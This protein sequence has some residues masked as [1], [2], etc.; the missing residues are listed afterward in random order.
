MRPMPLHQRFTLAPLALAAAMAIALAAG[1]APLA[2]AQ[3]GA[4]TAEATPIAINI[5]AQPLGQALNELARQANLQMTFP[6]EMVAGIQAPAVVGQLTARQALD[7]MLAGS[8]LVASVEGSSVVVRQAAPQQSSE[9]ALPEVTVTAGAEAEPEV[10]KEVIRFKRST[11]ATKFDADILETPASISSVSRKLIDE[12]AIRQADQALV[13]VPGLSYSGG[14]TGGTTEEFLIRGFSTNRRSFMDGYRN[15]FRFVPTDLLD[16]ERIDV[17][18]GAAGT[19]YGTAFPGGIVNYGLKKPQAESAHSLSASVGRYDYQRYEADSTGPITDDRT[20]QYRLLAAWQE[21]NLPASGQNNDALFDDRYRVKTQLRWL[22]PTG[23]TLDYS[24]DYYYVDKPIAGGIVFLRDG[25]FTFDSPPLI[26]EGSV[27]E[28]WNRRHVLEYVQPFG[29]GWQVLFGALYHDSSWNQNMDVTFG[30]ATVL[31]G[32]NLTRFVNINRDKSLIEQY[33]VEVSG[34]WQA[35]DWLEMRTI[36]GIEWVDDQAVVGT[37]QTV[38]VPNAIDP[39]N[40]V[41]GPRPA[42][43]EALGIEVSTRENGVFVQNLATI[44][45]KLNLLTGLRYLDYK[46]RDYLRPASIQPED[47]ALDY[48]VSASYR[49]RP[50]LAPFA[51]Y[52]TS[53]ELQFGTLNT[54]DVPPARRSAQIEAGVKSELFDDDLLLTATVYRIDQRDRVETIPGTN[55]PVGELVGEV[56]SQGFEFEFSGKVSER[57]SLYGGYAYTDA[58]VS[59][60]VLVT[61]GIAHQ[62]K[63]LVAV[64]TH[65]ASLYADY[66]FGGELAGLSL[67]A[68]VIRIVD[69]Q[70]DN[71]SRF[72]L[73]DYTRWDMGGSYRWQ[74]W[75]LSLALENLTDERYVV[76]SSDASFVYQGPRRSATATL[77]YAF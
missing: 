66:A 28:H 20:L 53:T 32:G 68:G 73:P 54:G 45:G 39:R 27:L 62:G 52:A 74:N 5:P 55:P 12:R 8:G 51:G 75:T 57:L 69:R 21:S 61:A 25:G 46:R 18:K 40:P 59:K 4:A 47:E 37:Q 2:H 22:A 42:T 44:H 14:N 63:P 10:A 16:V 7:R 38:F 72:K 70:G 64:P 3:S 67:N 48:T 9:V 43:N 58:F 56:R 34:A 1:H 50:W 26:A 19:L 17:L 24:F 31:D 71:L 76:G 77:R 23:G 41:F 33:R 6:A 13:F 30:P 11:A 65:Q 60:S 29:D 15:S 35:A 49:L 36:A